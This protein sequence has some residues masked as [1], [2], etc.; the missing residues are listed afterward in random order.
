[1]S[2]LYYNGLSVV[3]FTPRAAPN[4]S[5]CDDPEVLCGDCAALA[6]K[7]AGFTGNAEIVVNDDS[8]YLPQ[9]GADSPPTKCGA[10]PSKQRCAEGKP[11]PCDSDLLVPP[12]IDFSQGAKRGC[13]CGGDDSP[14]IPPAMSW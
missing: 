8:D 3:G 14:L 7:R 10:C 5:C 13:P 4:P 11:A 12:T 6:L 9:P 1:M 2:D